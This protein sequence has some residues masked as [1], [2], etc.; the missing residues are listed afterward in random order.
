M[1]EMAS[2]V[3]LGAGF[4]GHF[5]GP[6]GFDFEALGIEAGDDALSLIVVH[7]KRNNTN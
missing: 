5:A 3:G 2:G 7:F 6:L 4:F 1:G